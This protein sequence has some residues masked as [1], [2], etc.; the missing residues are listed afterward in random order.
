[1]SEHDLASSGR[2]DLPQSWIVTNDQRRPDQRQPEAPG[3]QL[4]QPDQPRPRPVMHQEAIGPPPVLQ[5]EDADPRAQGDRPVPE[6]R[7][8]RSHEPVDIAVKEGS[9]GQISPI[10]SRPA[11]SIAPR[12]S[13]A[14]TR[15]AARR[16]ATAG[17]AGRP[18]SAG[19]ITRRVAAPRSSRPD[20]RA[21]PRP[22]TARLALPRRAAEPASHLDGDRSRTPSGRAG[23]TAPGERDPRGGERGPAPRPGPRQP[24][25]VGCTYRP[26]GTG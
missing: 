5:A 8:D 7:E 21:G 14:S 11:R 10:A 18:T 12:A 19:A 6:H 20:A 22:A 1:M 9:A 23:A 2:R 4:R 13:S 25:A 26:R 15:I 24:V 16:S 17:A 3:E